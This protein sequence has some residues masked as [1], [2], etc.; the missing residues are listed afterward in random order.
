MR[1]NTLPIENDY[2]KLFVEDFFSILEC[3]FIGFSDNLIFGIYQIQSRLE[4]KEKY[5]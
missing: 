5:L 1:G 2:I 4:A 3:A